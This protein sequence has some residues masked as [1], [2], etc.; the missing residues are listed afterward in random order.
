MKN[1]QVCCTVFGLLLSLSTAAA[2][3]RLRFDGLDISDDTRLLF[4]ADSGSGR[5][6]VFVSRLTDLALQQVTAFPEQMELLENGRT[7]LV[8][9]SFGVVKISVT[10]G[11]PQMAP[12]FP[13]FA[14]G[15]V[16]ADGSS[17]AAAS[18]DGRW[19]LYIE[20]TGPADGDLI[21]LDLSGGAKRTISRKVELPAGNF[22]AT[23]SPD[24]RLFVYARGGRLYYYSLGY[25]ASEPVD[26]R[27]RQIGEGG[28]NALCWNQLGD[29]F[30]FKR[31]TLYRVRSPELY[32][33]TIYGDFL[34]IGSVAGSLP[35]G[36]D[37]LFDSFRVAP[38][39]RSI[40]L[41]KGGKNIFYYPLGDSGTASADS[42]LP[43][44]MIPGG[45][46]D[47]KV[48]W[49]PSGLVTVIASVLEGNKTMTWRFDTAEKTAAAFVPLK[50]PP[51]S[52]CV[53]SPD[54]SKA[55]FW[56]EEGLMLWDYIN[57]QPIE[58]VDWAP[59]YSCVWLNNGEYI[60]GNGQRIERISLSG[61]RRLV[62]LSNAEEYCFELA[63]ENPRMLA[64]SGGDWFASDGKSPWVRVVDPRRRPASQVSGRY[65][66]YLEGRSA[67]PYENI[68]MIRNVTSVGTASL[69]PGAG[70]QETGQ[71][72]K[73]AGGQKLALC[74]DLYDD[75]AGL[76]R[77]L[78]ALRR[79]GVKATFFLNGDFIRRH[80][81]SAAAIAEAGHEAAS[82]FYAPIDLADSRYRVS[83]DYIAQGLAR[84][85]DEFYG[86][87]GRELSLIWHPPFY[88]SSPEISA[89]A[90]NVGY[91]TAV[92]SLD[93]MDWLSR[94]EAERLGVRMYTASEMIEQIIED[95]K[96]GAIIPIRL[97]L[98]SGGS[99]DYLFLHIEV[100]LDALIRGGCDIVPVSAII[101]DGR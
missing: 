79:F 23:W 20:P 30:Y 45:A 4:R 12:G 42:L 58:T 72:A 5:Q 2:P 18:A 13:S 89:A 41:L 22:P 77:T 70:S 31:N 74:F 60:A 33:R 99:D 8:R 85:E 75:D 84:N 28:I 82:L 10:G 68:P 21:L 25:I 65:R 76:P 86:A 36:F 61:Q 100:L 92:R 53:L 93:P 32:T 95:K 15:N 81:V 64:R 26:E 47:V 19:I 17:G 3:A 98:L 63:G 62:C 38:D 54:G 34:S 90:A 39:S 43:Y 56:G 59:V 78:D 6:S 97:G 14:A 101:G 7:L 24:S 29:L 51:S 46:Y 40:L 1:R 35:L 55:L 83:D 49:S 48:L 91:L 87:T 16:P 67:G 73:A 57:W 69:L 37:P 66:V 44:V 71:S 9:N 94:E 27:Y 11:L 96:S 80:P 50:P 88:R 52:Q